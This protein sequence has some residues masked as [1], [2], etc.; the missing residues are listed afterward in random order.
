MSSP[1]DPGL[2]RGLLFDIDGTLSDTDDE[3]V[4]RLARL[5]TPLSARFP[6]LKPAV[7]ARKLL[8]AAESPINSLATWWDRL[9][10]D[11]LAAPV[12]RLLPRRRGPAS[13]EPLVPGVRAMLEQAH[14]RYRL[15]IVTARGPRLTASFLEGTELAPWFD[16][17]IHAR[18]V[19][20]TKPHP[21]PVLWAAAQLDL[22]PTA[23]LMIGDTT[24]DI[25]AGV[26]A[27]TQTIGVLCGFGERDELLRAG[28]NLTI[29]STADLLDHMGRA[30]SQ[31]PGG[32]S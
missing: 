8:M 1:F 2:V 3:F 5:L 24:P 10:L 29:D 12:A 6:R 13:A 31:R 19:R 14:D 30:D 18:T 22:E 23:C 32:R 16:V 26:A 7:T 4:K 15:G 28:A 9:F 17:A 20:R 11:E 27:G 25:L 21:E